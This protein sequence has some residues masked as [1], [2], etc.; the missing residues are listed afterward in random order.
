MVAILCMALAVL[1]SGQTY[2]SLMDQLD[3]AH[4]HA[5]FANPL[6][7]D[8]QVLPSHHDA[9]EHHHDHGTQ[10][11]AD[12][13]AH[14]AGEHRHS[15][16]PADHQHG[17]AAIVFLAAQSFVLITCPL[18]T[19]RCT[20]ESPRFVSISPRGPDHPPKSSLEIRV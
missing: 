12:H 1:L 11:A 6:A 14:S 8:I 16:N 3:H 9:A 2:I 17:D 13:H 4:H 5:H 10:D 18:V 19:D 7:G 15:H 20:T